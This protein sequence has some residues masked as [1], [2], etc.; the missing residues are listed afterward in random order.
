MS[1][2]PKLQTKARARLIADKVEPSKMLG[3]D[4]VTILKIAEILLP[5]L[6]DCFG[7]DDGQQAQRYV[8]KR[9]NKD[10]SDNDYRGYDK[11]LAKGMARRAKLAAR[12][13]GTSIT[14]GQAYEIGFK[15]LDDIRTGDT[16]QA[17]LAI[18][19]NIDFMLI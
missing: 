16:N 12:R 13:N 2:R 7:P 15:T 6:I 14:W 18:A 1:T 19:E 8:D 4:V 3:L 17:S 9:F 5:M 10:K 11:R